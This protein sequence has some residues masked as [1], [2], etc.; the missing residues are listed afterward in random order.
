MAFEL[1]S[2]AKTKQSKVNY[3]NTVQPIYHHVN[4][5]EET[6]DKK[7]D[8]P[9]N[10]AYERRQAYTNLHKGNWVE[11]DKVGHASGAMYTRQAISK[12]LGGGILGN[13]VGAVGANLLGVGHEV[14]AFNNDH[15]LV[16]GVIEGGKDIVNNFIGSISSSKNLERN[17]EKYGTDGMGSATRKERMADMKKDSPLNQNTVPSYSDLKK[18]AHSS[19]NES[20]KNVE[21]S[22]ANKKQISIGSKLSQDWD[23]QNPIAK[24][25]IQLA[26]P[27]GGTSYPDVKKAW[28][29]NKTTASDFIEPIG[30]LPLIGKLP[31]VLKLAKNMSTIT[32]IAQSGAKV[33]KITSKVNKVSK[34]ANQEKLAESVVNSPLHKQK[35][36]PKAAKAKAERDLAAAKTDDRRIKKAHSQRMHRKDP[37]GNGKDWDHEDGRWESVKQNRGNEG[38][39]TKKE[40]GKKYKI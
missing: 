9:V 22:K 19:L 7:L 27:T 10:K 12:K 23:N 40:S 24:A 4:K 3:E 26:D 28:S 15:G 13:V 34:I 31:K 8:Y 20:N 35:L 5:M 38:E 1:R 36:S 14:G 30:A 6:I 17:V 29:D 16:N 33:N 32:R 18:R 25:A 39:G 37:K 2:Q 11:S 21:K